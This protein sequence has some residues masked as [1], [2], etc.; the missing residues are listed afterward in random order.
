ME[1]AKFAFACN[2]GMTAHVTLM[3]LCKPG[4]HIL[5]VDDVYGGTR[6]YLQKIL[7]PNTNIEVTFSDFSDIDEFKK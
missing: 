7:N 2:S 6:R 1:Y 5:C 4:D 3:N